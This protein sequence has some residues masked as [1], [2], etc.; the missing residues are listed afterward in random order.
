M[1]LRILK[2]D[3]KRKK[4][5]NIILLVFIILASM[6]VA[7]S[8]NNIITVT[9]ALDSYYEKAGGPDYFVATRGADTAEALRKT[10]AENSQITDY[11]IEDVIY[12]EGDAFYCEGEK[13]TLKNTSIIMGYDDAAINFF[14]NDN[15]I[16][17]EVKEGTVVITGKT[18]K[19]SGLKE[20]DVIDITVN[21][22][23]VSLAVTESC[24]DVILGSDMMGMSRFILNGK[25]YEKLCNGDNPFGG[26]LWYINSDDISAVETVLNKEQGIIFNGD[27]AMLKMT[28]FLDMVIAGVLLVVSVSLILVAF[29]VLHFTITFTLSEEFREIGVMKAIGIG[30][31]KIRQLYM[32]K[33]FVM[34]AVGAAVGFFASIPFGNML[35]E[36]VSESLVFENKN[37]FLINFLCCILVV[38]VILLFCYG[39][40]G[41]I[42]K[43][44]PI[45]AV[46]NGTTGERFRQKS[47]LHLENTHAKP[48]VFMAFNDILSSP[49]R[50]ASIIVIYTLCMLLVLILVN[51]T[52]T[53]RSDKLVT[54]FGVHKSDVYFVESESELMSFMVPE[55]RE[56]MEKKLKEIE[57]ILAENNMPADCTIEVMY[58]YNL[59]HEGK[60]CKSMTLQGIGTTTDMYEYHEGT[61]PQNINEIAVTPLIAEKLGA[62][63][64]DKVT[65]DN[66]VGEKEYIITALYQS[67]N[68]LGEGVRLHQDVDTDIGQASGYFNYQVNFKDNPDKKTVKERVKRIKEIF[69][70]DKA[71][72]AGEYVE[73]MTGT[74]DVLDGV[75]MLTLTIVI[76]IIAL[77]TI[78]MERSFITKE[79]SEIAVIKAIGFKT[80][81]C[82]SW[83]TMRFII[84]GIISTLIAAVIST[85][86]TK[87][88][89][90]PIF[91]V[92]GASFGISYEI[93]PLE[94][95]VIYPAIVLAVTIF[96][97]ML[98]ALYTRTITAAQASSIE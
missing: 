6:F 17:K 36:S 5:M 98:T 38:A 86:V 97:A 58:K 43:F 8:V 70:A 37:I 12:A 15:N 71:Y 79:Q 22:I 91:G 2:K 87:L 66:G 80:G 62:G 20:G 34:A 72:T 88:A 14:D 68:N 53:L 9:T 57:D 13:L 27:K 48:A 44:T 30:N 16:I 42:K 59:S 83:H 1:Y 94:V 76:I 84:T 55:G 39:C 56:M 60:N 54:S 32:V 26:H 31:V 93:K 63:I 61:P 74:A 25:D 23:T 4:T 69:N 65:I 18:M 67:M 21:G 19:S 85:P 82:V 78:L 7:S 28:Y 51:T 33:Y 45:D 46:R 29:V 73:I 49:K 11:K 47:V 75:K 50:Y 41:K 81:F 10:L 24:K 64:G 90:T 3:L 96:C 35:L 77:V 92:M 89:V 52:N 40:T 95:F